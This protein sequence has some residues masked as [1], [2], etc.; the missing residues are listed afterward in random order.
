[1]LAF[2]YNGLAYPCLR[3]ME[4]SLGNKVKPIVI[5][6]VDGIYNTEETK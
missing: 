6:N 4:S 2:D 3:Y 5:G 1:M